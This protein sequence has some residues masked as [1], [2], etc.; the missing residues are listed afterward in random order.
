MKKNKKITSTRDIPYA[1]NARLYR[2][3]S[4]LLGSSEHKYFYTND[5]YK[6]IAQFCQD[7]SIHLSISEYL[8]LNFFFLARNKDKK[9]SDFLEKYL[10]HEKEMNQVEFLNSH[11]SRAKLMIQALET[12]HNNEKPVSLNPVIEASVNKLSDL[13]N[14]YCGYAEDEFEG[15]AKA[16]IQDFYSTHEHLI[17]QEEAYMSAFL[18]FEQKVKDNAPIFK[19]QRFQQLLDPFVKTNIEALMYHHKEEAQ[20]FNRYRPTLN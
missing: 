4:R 13:L 9:G 10:N 19:T 11:I 3:F 16:K 12:Q 2:N 17:E 18:S 8:A 14:I 5:Y 20:H 7:N 6:D 1:F 15:L